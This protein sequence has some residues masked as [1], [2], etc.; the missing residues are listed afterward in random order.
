MKT[1]GFQYIDG[2]E[3]VNVLAK[4]GASFFPL[5]TEHMPP[6]IQTFK[7]VV[8]STMIMKCVQRWEDLNSCLFTKKRWKPYNVKQTE[9]LLH[10]SRPQCRLLVGVLRVTAHSRK[11]GLGTIDICKA[12]SE[13]EMIVQILC[14]RQALA[15]TQ[16]RTVSRTFIADLNGVSS[17]KLK[18]FLIFFGKTGIFD[19]DAQLSPQSAT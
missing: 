19:L 16:L 6:A 12:P 15:K 1:A 17:S 13:R 5:R 8:D 3:M 10:Q 9:F 7:P 11:V 14:Y 2:N 4:W 18:K